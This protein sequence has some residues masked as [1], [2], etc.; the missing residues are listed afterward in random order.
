MTNKERNL[1]VIETTLVVTIVFFASF[2]GNVYAH[3]LGHYVAADMFGLSPRISY[4]SAKD[5]LNFGLESKAL[6]YTEFNQTENKEQMFFIALAGP[7]VNLLLVMIFLLI[8]IN[9]RH[10]PVIQNIAI[11]GLIP[12]IFSFVVNILPYA[13]SD[14][15]A[16]ISSIL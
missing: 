2:L 6:A 10:I 1:K 3:E 16:I 14:G 4:E 7:L 11:G 12:S 8:Y 13:S 9:Y 5:T 15:M